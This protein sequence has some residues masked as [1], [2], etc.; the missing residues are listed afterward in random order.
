MKQRIL[1][2]MFILL[3]S[4]C[5]IAQ[6]REQRFRFENNFN[7]VLP[8]CAS[9]LNAATSSNNCAIS[10]P[11][12][13]FGMDSVGCQTFRTIYR[14]KT[15]RGLS[16]QNS[17]VSLTDEYTI[18]LYVKNLKWGETPVKLV[19]FGSGNTE[20][21]MI[22]A[23]SKTGL[24]S[25]YLNSKNLSDPKEEKLKLNQYYLLT[26]TRNK[27][28][29]KLDI[30]IENQRIAIIDDA[31]KKFV[32]KTNRTILIYSQPPSEACQTGSANFAHLL[33]SNEYS[34]GQKVKED[35]E[36]RCL[37]S[38]K[39]TSV[40][41]EID[42]NASCKNQNIGI[43]FIGNIPES[44]EYEFQ[45]DFKDGI[46]V[47]GS[48]RGPYVVRWEK[49]GKIVP[50]LKIINKV[51][52]AEVITSNE[53]YICGVSKIEMEVEDICTGIANIRLQLPSGT[54]PFY[55][56]FNGSDFSEKNHF[57]APNGTYKVLFMDAHRCIVDTV[58]TVRLKEPALIKT[59]EDTTICEGE[60]VELLTTTN[61]DFIS[62]NPS[63]DMSDY[64]A[65]SPVFYPKKTTTYVGTASKDIC[66]STD[67]VTV[68]V[69]PSPH[70]LVSP[71][72]EV[73]SLKPY[74]LFALAYPR[75]LQNTLTYLWTPP[76][77]L[78]NPDIPLPLATLD[79]TQ[80]YVISAT[81][82][83]GCSDIDSTTIRVRKK[84]Y[85]YIPTA[86][87][88]NQDTHN[89]LFIPRYIAIK[90]LSFFT[91]YSRDGQAV[92]H[93]TDPKTGW[94]GTFRGRDAPAGTYTYLI[95][96]TS[97]EGDPVERR[98]TVLLIR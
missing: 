15:N 35:Y 93:T 3:C 31:R 82:S 36:N 88:P 32:G 30:Y 59:I 43:K 25:V 29:N 78:D 1:A 21:L 73:E 84:P 70:I 41:F 54:L 47:S 48:G 96:A 67:S 77:G 66:V 79:S 76:K 71:D 81:N 62:W 46:V 53:K 26:I 22:R 4:F 58:L 23:D 11:P 8:A 5:A 37:M 19:D 57:N 12:S 55:Y 27:S 17:Q 75:D 72:A 28:T 42:P 90:T 68:T 98:G 85:I 2:I 20:A 89:Q 86:F 74:Q 33:V 83:Y 51:C 50:T 60:S 45:W 24:G 44:S 34:S 49:Q 13:G 7:G 94:D 38:K 69:L 14:S 80:T 63:N 64:T 16:Y 52:G 87:T 56:S 9:E 92:F 61:A 97:I 39:D 95:R 10:H 65:R 40:Q 6:K 91:I 18:Q